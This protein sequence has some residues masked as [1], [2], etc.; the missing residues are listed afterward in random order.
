MGD[1]S[2]GDSFV[3]EG[4]SKA[5]GLGEATA[6]T[7]P[8]KTTEP[9]E[10]PKAEEKTETK[11]EPKAEEPTENPLS[12]EL[13]N[14]RQKADTAHRMVIELLGEKFNELKA[15]R[16]SDK[17]MRAWFDA[18]PDFA[19]VANR[20]KKWKDS[21][22]TLMER[23]PAAKWKDERPRDVEPEETVDDDD[24]QDRTVNPDNKILTKDDI[25]SILDER[26]AR[27][28]EKQL[29]QTQKALAEQYAISRGLKDE[30]YERFQTNVDAIAKANPDWDNDQVFEAAANVVDPGKKTPVNLS[31]RTAN[32]KEGE[33]AVNEG[34]VSRLQKLYNIPREK[35]VR[36]LQ[37]NDQLQNITG[38]GVSLMSMDDLR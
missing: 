2:S 22:R 29:K 14:Y 20:S 1:Q 37:S 13:K 25:V 31:N 7:T 24:P 27:L 5:F 28:L 33:N 38:A 15:G 4:D 19:E 30:K 23:D 35:A 12:D 18:H 36:M 21:Y 11:E 34:E 6:T 9:V 26:E 17:E 8:Q 10:T 16:M 32:L 3:A